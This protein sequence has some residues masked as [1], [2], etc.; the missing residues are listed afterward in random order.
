M[1]DTRLGKS[2]GI[3]G[4]VWPY[5]RQLVDV[6]DDL[7]VPLDGLTG[8]RPQRGAEVAEAAARGQHPTRHHPHPSPPLLAFP[9]QK[10]KL[11]FIQEVNSLFF[12]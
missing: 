11:F 3:T 8:P 1:I 9:S 7:L 5:R 2:N 12:G 4:R 6:R 10:A